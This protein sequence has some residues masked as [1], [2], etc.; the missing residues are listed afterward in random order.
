MFSSIL[1]YFPVF[2]IKYFRL[3][4]VRGLFP[5]LNMYL[6]FSLYDI[7]QETVGRQWAD[8]GYLHIQRRFVI[9]T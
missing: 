1:G 6:T 3:G 9:C 2:I 5:R 8:D 7:N 4:C